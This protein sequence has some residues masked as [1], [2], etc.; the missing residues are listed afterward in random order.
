MPCSIVDNEKGDEGHEEA[1]GAADVVDAA[2]DEVGRFA[3][4]AHSYCVVA[5]SVRRQKGYTNSELRLVSTWHSAYKRGEGR[6]NSQADLLRGTPHAAEPRVIV[7]GN[8]TLHGQTQ[9]D[10]GW[11][12]T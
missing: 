9:T 5:L 1:E 6:E 7:D 12:L 3:D 8:E 2:V 4:V 10:P 11:E